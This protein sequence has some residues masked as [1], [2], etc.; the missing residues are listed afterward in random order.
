MKY[1]RSIHEVSTFYPRSIHVLSTK[2]PRF[3]L[4][5]LSK[6]TQSTLCDTWSCVPPDT[7]HCLQARNKKPHH[8][9]GVLYAQFNYLIKPFQWF[10]PPPWT[11]PLCS[12]LYQIGRISPFL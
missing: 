12:M 7:L 10:I 11:S 1:P 5:T 9:D 3:N 2:Y 8:K 4:K 6:H